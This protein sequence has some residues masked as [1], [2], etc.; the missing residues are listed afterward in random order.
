MLPVGL[1]GLEHMGVKFE[2]AFGAEVTI[3]ST[4]AAKENDAKALGAHHFVVT[5]DPEQLAS[6]KSS[7]DFILDTVSAKHDLNLYLSLLKTNGTHICIGAPSEP[8]QVPPFSL[9]AGNK[10]G[11]LKFILFLRR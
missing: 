5:T 4:S 11:L 10:T 3:L 9:L 7:F 6:V 8:Y 1:G 2:V